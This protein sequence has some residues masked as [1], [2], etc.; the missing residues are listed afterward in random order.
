MSLARVLR[1]H[2]DGKRKREANLFS[3]V[4]N[5][6]NIL[7]DEKFIQSRRTLRKD[8]LLIQLRESDGNTNL[9]REI[10]LETEEAARNV[11]T[12]YD[13]LGFILKHDKELEDEF[14]QWQSYVIADIWMLTKELVTKK[15]RKRN[16]MYLKEFERLGNKA[17]HNEKSI[18][19]A[20]S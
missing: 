18:D 3:N 20:F 10:D 13:R 16:K 1:S 7:D 12:T 17:I 11:A 5:I 14:L 6:T 9:I 2:S 19:K 8:K 4:T 15:W